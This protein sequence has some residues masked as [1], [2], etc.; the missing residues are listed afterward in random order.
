MSG[1]PVPVHVPVQC[2]LALMHFPLG[3]FES[4]AQRQPAVFEVQTGAGESGVT[5]A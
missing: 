4:S 3:Q 2:A 5:Q 1:A